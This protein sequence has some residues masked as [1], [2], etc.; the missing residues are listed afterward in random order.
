MRNTHS[1]RGLVDMLTAGTA[2]SISIDTKIL[3]LYHYVIILG[4]DRHYHAADE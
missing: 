3:I 1:T 4:Y 2:A